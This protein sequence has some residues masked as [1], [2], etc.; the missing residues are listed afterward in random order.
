MS[1]RQSVLIK[2][3]GVQSPAVY[4]DWPPRFFFGFSDIS[5]T[6]WLNLRY[7]VLFEHSC[8]DLHDVA[9][10]L[11]LRATYST[12]SG[13][14]HTLSSRSHVWRVFCVCCDRSLRLCGSPWLEVRR[15]KMCC[16]IVAFVPWEVT[17]VTL[18]FTQVT[19][20]V[21]CCLQVAFYIV[22]WVSW[23]LVR[24]TPAFAVVRPYG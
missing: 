10:V 24:R 6:F 8:A 1:A 17:E 2:R 19:L 15:Y 9:W 5:L 11:F 3:C 12:C 22:S 7:V 4:L 14:S 18:A 23:R 20:K 21:S 16:L 13:M